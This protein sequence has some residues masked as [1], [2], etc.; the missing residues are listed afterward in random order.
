MAISRASLLLATAFAYIASCLTIPEL[1]SRGPAGIS[2]RSTNGHVNVAYFANWDIYGRNYQPNQI[3]IDRLTHI[4]YCFANIQSDGTVVL[5]DTYADLQKHYSTDSWNDVGNNVYGNVKQLYLLKK[6]NR[7]LKV[8]LS[9]GGWTV[10][11]FINMIPKN[12]SESISD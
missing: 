8:L 6:Q 4:M 2:Q 10:S 11:G 5:S 9:I 12:A 1:S 7:N 3:P